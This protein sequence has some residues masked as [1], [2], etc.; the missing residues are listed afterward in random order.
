MF[1]RKRKRESDEQPEESLRVVSHDEFLRIQLNHIERHREYLSEQR[2]EDVSLLEASKDWCF[3]G[4]ADMLR[5]NFKVVSNRKT[6]TI[7]EAG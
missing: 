4:W 1:G 6:H 7:S 2:G 5:K 3:N